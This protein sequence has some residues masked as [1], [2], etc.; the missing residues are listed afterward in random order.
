MEIAKKAVRT[1][2]FETM[3]FPFNFITNEPAEELIPLC[4]ESDVGFIV[5]KPMGGG[6]LD[7]ATIAF[8]YLRRFPAIVPIPGIERVEEIAEIVALMEAPSGA[9]TAAEEA[10][11][12]RL[13]EELGTQFCRRCG[14]CQPCPE[15]VPITTLMIMETIIKR[16]PI[17]TVLS[18][19]AADAVAASENCIKC[20]E[21]ESKCPYGLPIRDRMDEQ[22]ALFR[23]LTEAG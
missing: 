11:M 8:K 2:H 15:G 19:W 1:G 14:Y 4:L 20:G 13:R 17:E 5:M 18:G 6:M 16:M 21:C 22:V 12:A 23:A 7:N 9:L 3:M 10:E